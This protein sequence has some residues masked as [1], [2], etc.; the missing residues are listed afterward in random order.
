VSNHETIDELERR[1]DGP[2]PPELRAVAL[3]GGEKPLALLRARSE[4]RQWNRMIRD[5]I[6]SLRLAGKPHRVG[7]LSEALAYHRRHRRAVLR[8]LIE[9]CDDHP[10]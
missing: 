6:A 10:D 9:L 8:R 7:A 5:T 4:L 2:I 1:F 3:A